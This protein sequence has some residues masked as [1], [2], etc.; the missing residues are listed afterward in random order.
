MQPKDDK[1]SFEFI[2][3]AL[4]FPPKKELPPEDNVMSPGYVSVDP[5]TG[6]RYAGD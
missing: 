4:G 1:F 3:K 6:E 2:N 5:F